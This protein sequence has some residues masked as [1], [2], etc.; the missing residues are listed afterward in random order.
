MDAF[1]I[2]CTTD[3]TAT[4]SGYI[5]ASLAPATR[6]GYLSDLSRFVTWGGSIPTSEVVV[7]SYIA[8]HARSHAAATL[9]RWLASISKAHRAS[10]ATDP[11]KSELVKATLRGIRRAHGVAQDQATALV[12]EDL[13]MVLDAM[14]DDLKSARDRALLLLGFA[15]GFRRSEL[16]GLDVSDVE[17]VRQGVVI[18]IRRSKSDQL[19]Q[20]RRIGIPYGRTRNCPVA[21]LDHWLEQS[22]VETGPIFRPINRHGKVRDCRLSGEA[23]AIVIKARVTAVGLDPIGYSGHS[24]RAGFATSAAQSGVSSWKIR[25]QTGHKSEAMLARY[26]R[27]GELFIDNAA[28]TIL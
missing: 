11:T 3:L 23:V 28:A 4:V 18:V 21:A 9:A 16:I 20:G 22:G 14:D 17:H 12:R 2:N 6:S 26:V 13:F 27:E 7:A 10:S 24:L 8:G 1:A 5:A 15:G 19:A 25:T